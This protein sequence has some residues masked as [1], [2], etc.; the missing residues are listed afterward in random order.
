VT[1]LVVIASVFAFLG[2]FGS[3]VDQQV[4]DTNEWTVRSSPA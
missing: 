3:W 1:T 2:I 4:F